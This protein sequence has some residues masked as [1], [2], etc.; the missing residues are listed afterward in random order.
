MA[1][2][3]HNDPIR[4]SNQVIKVIIDNGN[5]ELYLLAT[6]KYSG[7]IILPFYS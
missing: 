7:V 5:R 2:S 6:L 4:S 1:L 3:P